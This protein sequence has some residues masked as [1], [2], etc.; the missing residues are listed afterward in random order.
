MAVNGFQKKQL[1]RIVNPKKLPK[2]ELTDWEVGFQEY[3]RTLGEEHEFTPAENK[4]LNE[5]AGLFA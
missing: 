3:L 5:V 4:K 2:R 1:E